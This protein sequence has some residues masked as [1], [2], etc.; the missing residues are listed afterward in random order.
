[1]KVE[2][3]DGLIEIVGQIAG[4]LCDT[5]DLELAAGCRS[6]A[7]VFANGILVLEKLSGERLIDDGDV[8]RACSVLL[9]DAP[10]IDD[11]SS[12]DAKVPAGTAIPPS[13]AVI[14]W[15]GSRVAIY[16]DAGIPTTAALR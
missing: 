10:A 9:G 4:I 11:R 8:T 15:S 13:E 12:A 2:R 3:A 5:D 16:R 1:K 14:V 7:E 6:A